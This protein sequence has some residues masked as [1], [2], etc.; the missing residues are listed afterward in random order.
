MSVVTNL[1]VRQSFVVLSFLLSLLVRVV[2]PCY[3]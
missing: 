3:C 1:L 2:R